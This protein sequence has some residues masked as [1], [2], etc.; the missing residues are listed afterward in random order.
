MS[1]I[2]LSNQISESFGG[3]QLFQFIKIGKLTTTSEVIGVY[4]D[5]HQQAA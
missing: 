2:E 5:T 3:T 1:I 4:S